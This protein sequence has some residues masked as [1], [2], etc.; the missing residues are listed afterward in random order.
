MTGESLKAL[1]RSEIQVFK[2]ELEFETQNRLEGQKWQCV[3]SIGT[4]KSTDDQ[5]RESRAG[6][7]HS[8]SQGDCRGHITP[9]IQ[10]TQVT[11]FPSLDLLFSA[12]RP[13]EKQT[14]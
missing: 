2:D 8:T 13:R 3:H 9:T 5:S 12:R 11:C 4:G 7:R 1:A 10:G 14:E 6:N